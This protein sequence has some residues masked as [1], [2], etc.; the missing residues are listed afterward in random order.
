[1]AIQQFNDSILILAGKPID[2]KF[3]PYNSIAD[4]N[5]AIPQA[6]RHAGLIFGIYTLP[7]DIPNSD[8]EYYCYYGDFTDVEYR[9]LINITLQEV[10]DNGNTTTNTIIHADA[11]NNNE[12][13]TLGQVIQLINNATGGVTGDFVPYTGATKNVIL[14]DFN[15]TTDSVKFDLTPV[16]T[17][18]KGGLLWNE[19]NGSL[20][21][22]LNTNVT[23]NIG[24]DDHILVRN[25]S[26]TTIPKGRVVS[27][28]GIASQK[29]LIG[30]SDGIGTFDS[31]YILGVTSEDILNNTDGYVIS[32]G[33]LSGINTT[34][35]L[36]AETWVNGDFLYLNPSVLGG[37]TKNIP[38][39]P[40]IKTPIAIVINSDITNGVLELKI[41]LSSEINDLNNVNIG[42]LSNRH[43][44]VYNTTIGVWENKTIG[45]VLNGTSSQFVKGNGSL[46]ST[47]Y[48]PIITGAA[49]TI[50][51]NNLTPDKVLISDGNGKVA[52]SPI[53]SEELLSLSGVTG[54]IQDQIDAIT[55]QP[56]VSNVII[57]E[58]FEY[59][60]GNTITLSQTPDSIHLVNVNGQYIPDSYYSISGDT[61]TFTNITFDLEPEPDQ[62]SI[63]YF[64]ETI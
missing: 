13:A 5:L 24:L 8:V 54:N 22:G 10:T 7:S 28:V 23:N 32:R 50:T 15:I 20:N 4:A 62:I 25:Q 38:I 33:R 57:N 55:S 14:G 52:V 1:M 11:I 36:Y 37:L 19:N 48:Q 3:G 59:L 2:D 39:G 16:T 35:S 47:V 9:K 45:Y 12:S 31:N 27:I 49:T 41:K 29:I 44:L 30:L 40:K 64:K 53:T 51:N 17:Q 42:A 26:G 56:S 21:L 34:G 43:L 6:R 46:D 63:H 60:S 18:S 58:I 61:V